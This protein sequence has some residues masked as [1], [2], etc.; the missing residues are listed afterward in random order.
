MAVESKSFPAMA[1]APIPAV[2]IR[3]QSE[4]ISDALR[5]WL[6]WA[7]VVIAFLLVEGAVWAARL[8]VRSR[9]ALSAG[10]TV[11]VFGLVDRPSLRRLGLGLPNTLGGSLTLAASFAT[12]VVMVFL[13]RG[14]GGPI[15]ANPTFPN[16]HL[17]WQYLIWALLQEFMLQ[18]FFYTRFEE[19]LGS[20]TAVWV[21]ATVF[22]MVH[23]PNMILTTSTLIGGL[24]FCEMF[25]RYRSIYPLAI[26]HAILGLTLSITVPDVLLMHMRVGIGYLR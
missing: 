5:R 9:W 12:A 20:S 19:L 25:R 11:I 17:A 1:A 14:A 24:F 6:T 23:L 26:A 18:S 13:A 8:S 10:V 7:Q 3:V 21:T 16:M 4:G 2:A 22:A 15:P